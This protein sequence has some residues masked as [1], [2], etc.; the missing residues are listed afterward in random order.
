MALTNTTTQVDFSVCQKQGCSTIE[1]TDTTGLYDAL[2]NPDG[3]GSDVNTLIDTITGSLLDITFPDD[4]TY[5]ININSLYD[6]GTFPNT[7]NLGILLTY[8]EA[9]LSDNF[10]DGVYIFNYRV[11]GTTTE[12]P[13]A[14]N[15]AEST[16]EKYI[17]FTCQTQ[18][19]IDN[20]FSKVSP[21]DCGC[22]ENSALQAVIKAQ[23]YLNAACEAMACGKSKLASKLLKRAQFEASKNNCKSC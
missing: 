2:L 15:V 20:M 10:P 17:L 11:Q 16:Q 6:L 8:A 5:S 14:E 12:V 23:G 22:D 7:A 18:C 13:D 3:Y 21:E 9:G 4:T 19:S 1:L